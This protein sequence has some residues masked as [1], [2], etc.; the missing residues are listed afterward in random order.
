[1]GGT[2]KGVSFS[3]SSSNL[4]P[5]SKTTSYGKEGGRHGSKG[6]RSS[7]RGGGHRSRG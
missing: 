4:D 7:S 3:P 1:L 6:G 2:G 5:L